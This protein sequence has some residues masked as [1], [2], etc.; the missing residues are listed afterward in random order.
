MR[1]D[2]ALLDPMRRECPG[3]VTIND[4]AYNV[5]ISDFLQL[6]F[7]NSFEDSDQ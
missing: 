1:R 2:E 7:N 6:F 3:W 5:D 4:P